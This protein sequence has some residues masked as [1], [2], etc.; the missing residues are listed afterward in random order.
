MNSIS[1]ETLRAWL[2]E[3]RQV[4]LVDVRLRTE[5]AEGVTPGCVHID[6]Y[7]ALKAQIPQPLPTLHCLL[8]VQS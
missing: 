5:R 2:E 6:A 3:G 8:I 1:V 7:D 4:S